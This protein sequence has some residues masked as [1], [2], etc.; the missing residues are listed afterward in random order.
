MPFVGRE[1]ELRQ[2]NDTLARPPV[3]VLIEG[4]A[5]VGKTRLLRELDGHPM[6]SGSCHPMRFPYGPIVEALRA[7]R[8]P[9]GLNPVTGALRPLLPEC[10]HL[11]PP[12]PPPLHNA[13]VE[14]HRLFRG[15]LSLLDALR[16]ITLV[17]ED[18]HWVDQDTR[19]LLGFLARC[20]P[21]AVNL[22]LTYRAEDLCHPV[23]ELIAHLPPHIDHVEL[24]LAPLT[25]EET[26][27]LAKHLLPGSA[28]LWPLT[29]GLP[30]AIEELARMLAQGMEPGTPPALRDALRLRLDALPP[31]ARRIVQAAAMLEE[32][33]C[34]HTLT[35]VAGM[36]PEQGERGLA[37]AVRRGLLREWTP[38]T[39]GLRQ[40]LAR[41]AV[42]ESITPTIRRRLSRRIEAPTQPVGVLSP[43]EEQVIGLAADGLTNREIAESLFLSRRTVEV[44]V[45]NALRKLGLTSRRQLSKAK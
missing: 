29:G 37:E 10:A 8:P 5:G 22:V 38:G 13:Q 27:L 11:L 14:R 30:L 19:E 41:Q 23:T 12:A 45:A 32:P 42:R 26:E 1:R 9:R 21:E 6:L 17:V 16:P 40:P 36:L 2:L 18:V 43:R 33:A 4:E 15:V 7:A 28:D 35:T 3:I 44:H 24:A 31:V 25:A 20:L 39:Y 34:L